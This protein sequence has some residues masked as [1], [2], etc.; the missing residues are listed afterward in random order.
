MVTQHLLQFSLW[1]Y[2]KERQVLERRKT[3]KALMSA[4]NNFVVALHSSP[5]LYQNLLNHVCL[6]FPLSLSLRLCC[7]F[8]LSSSRPLTLFTRVLPSR[9]DWQIQ[10]GPRAS[11]LNLKVVWTLFSIVIQVLPLEG[12]S[13]SRKHSLNQSWDRSLS[14]ISIDMHCLRIL[15]R[16]NKHCHQ[17]KNSLG[18][19][20]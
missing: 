12:Q 18:K 19:V 11:V 8:C 17:R 4:G 5:I 20:F 2:S 9:K 10:T 14:D 13:M 15:F 3:S 1:V 6:S 7:S 16:Q